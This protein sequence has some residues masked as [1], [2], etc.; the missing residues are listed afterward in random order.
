MPVEMPDISLISDSES[1]F[2][3]VQRAQ[4][5]K[6]QQNALRRQNAVRNALAPNIDPATGQINYQNA[7]AMGGLDVAP[8]L[9]A[10]Q[11]ADLLAQADYN[12]KLADTRNT[13]ATAGK[14]ST[15]QQIAEMSQF[16]SYLAPVYDQQAFTAWRT[17]YVQK[18][19]FLDPIIPKVY[20]PQ[21]KADLLQGTKAKIEALHFANEGAMENVGRDARTGAM[22]T[23][24][25][26]QVISPDEQS[27][28]NRE[29]NPNNVANITTNDQGDVRF[30]NKQ[31]GEVKPGAGKGAGKPAGAVITARQKGE[32]LKGDINNTISEFER[33]LKPGGLL[34]QSTGSG[35]GAMVDAAAA[36]GGIATEGAIAIGQLQ[37]IADLSLKLVERFEGPQSDND[38]ISY[39]EASANVANASLP[40]PIRKAAAATVLRI[41]KKRRDQFGY[42]DA[43]GSVVSGG[44]APSTTGGSDIDALVDR[45]R[46]K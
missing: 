45:H 25:V 7:Y 6:Q 42:R 20:S 2:A 1:I 18:Y 23:S 46:T 11:Q 27:R 36:F 26:P 35:A 32:K 16:A 37:P 8:E 5:Y 40:I 44:T 41:L 10:A 12:K 34:D 28:I 30:W 9:R 4:E 24:G 3:P 17:P 33:I 31:G 38:R 14:T 39:K 29:F 22:V 21:V 15:E 19:P 13:N 43:D